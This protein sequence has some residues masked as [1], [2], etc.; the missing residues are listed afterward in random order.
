MVIV[1]PESRDARMLE[2]AADR[3]ADGA[4]GGD[5]ADPTA[6][7]SHAQAQNAP[8]LTELL[9]STTCDPQER[10]RNRPSLAART[11]PSRRAVSRRGGTAEPED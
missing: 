1:R 2:L 3:P 9:G 8:D 11:G 7:C 5:E 10:G 6:G 4:A